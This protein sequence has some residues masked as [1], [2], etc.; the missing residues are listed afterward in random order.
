MSPL[1]FL[2][3]VLPSAG[4]YCAFTTQ[5]RQHR[6]ASDIPTLG[7]HI[8]QFAAANCDTYYALASF[9]ES[10]SRTAENALFMRAFFIDLDVGDD[11][12]KTYASA[13]DAREALDQF[14]ASATLGKLGAPWIVASGGGLHAYWPLDADAS[15]SEWKPVAETFKRV[16]KAGGL[17]IDFTVTA[18]AARVLRVPGTTHSGVKNGK[19][20]HEP[21]L[22]KIIQVGDMFHLP[23][24]EE[25]LRADLADEP[26]PANI[27][28]IPGK[29]PTRRNGD[30]PSTLRISGNDDTQF[31]HIL[32][33]TVAGSGC[34]QLQYYCEH[35]KDDNMEPLWRAW[36]SIT[37]VCS[38]G[39]HASRVLTDMHPYT[40]QRMQDKLREIKG[41]YPCLKFDSE[42]PGVCPTCPHWGKITNPL[43]LGRA[44]LIDNSPK[45]VVVESAGESLPVLVQR[46]TPPKGFSYGA[47][48]GVYRTIKVPDD[49]GAEVEK[50][51][52]ILWYDLFAVDVLNMNGEHIVHLVAMRPEGATQIILPQK[53]VVSKDETVKHLAGQ[54]VVAAFGAGNDKH[55]FDYVRACVEELS[56]SRKALKVPSSFGWA[57]ETFVFNGAVY[58]ANGKVRMPMPGL[59]NLIA[60]T[61]PTGSLERWR[62]VW[63]MLVSRKEYD[64]LSM[65]LV[66]FAAPLMRFTGLNGMTFHLGSTQSGTGKTLALELAGS[67]WGH[68]IHYR[69]G[70]K[71]SDVAMQQ[72]LGLLRNL[73]LISDEITDKNRRDFEWFPGFL[74]DMSEGRGKERMES[75]A[76]KERLNLSTWCTLSLMSSNTHVVD[77]LTGA[78]Q[79]TS[80][81]ELRRLLEMIF[82]TPMT[83]QPHEVDLIRSLPLH[84]GTA[85]ERWVEWLVRNVAVAEEMVRKVQRK[86]FLDFNASNDERF[87][88]AGVSAIIAA[89]ILINSKHADIIDIPTQPIIERLKELI[90]RSRTVVR[91]SVRTA[92]DVLNAYTREHYGRFVVLRWVDGAF[93]ATYG[94]R[95]VVDESLTRTQVFGRV[96]HGV[97]PGYVNYY[98]E[99]QLLKSYCSSMSFGYADFKRDIAAQ[100]VVDYGKRDLL[101]KTKGPQMRVNAICIR[102]P[103]SQA[104][105]FNEAAEDSLPVDKGAP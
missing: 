37:R 12:D 87:W 28:N 38:D 27:L 19:R 69:V 91:A 75:G 7:E 99:E 102:R 30:A 8:E 68:P 59:E 43:A 5:R 64:L 24:V 25:A 96:E 55:L 39:D 103:E 61:H 21:R 48:G 41:P 78:R 62:E 23:R 45:E 100:Y 33:R 53:A 82:D 94:E 58:S 79:H 2:A 22:V 95:G 76:N 16:C 15:I 77:Y 29:R 97:T 80:E 67:V 70:S 73:P 89:A 101:S 40:E 104:T 47:K 32:N 81:G 9:A 11:K 26:P 52:P 93:Q 4:V 98:I 72:R 20:V 60:N 90:T 1:D 6:F 49:T 105:E 88:V 57:D 50:Q 86:V 34:G 84:Y 17:K 31:K 10:G 3:V 51:V 83:W 35:A 92:E 14:L 66:G 74:F 54:N 46:P 18:D 85:G 13:E 71:T 65:A 36:L 44:T 42:N 63:M 56:A